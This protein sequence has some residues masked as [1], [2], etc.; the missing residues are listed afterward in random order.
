MQ[1]AI[2]TGHLFLFHWQE[3]LE[4][5]EELVSLDLL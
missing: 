1:F 3:C 2:L 4:W 5:V